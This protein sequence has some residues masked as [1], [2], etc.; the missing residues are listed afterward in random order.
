M[1]YLATQFADF[2]SEKRTKPDKMIPKVQRLEQA[3]IDA[4]LQ[5]YGSFK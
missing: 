2:R 1:P 5:Y 4:L 3:D